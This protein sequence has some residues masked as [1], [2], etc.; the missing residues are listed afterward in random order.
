MEKKLLLLCAISGLALLGSCT[1]PTAGVLPV[2]PGST[3]EKAPVS[4]PLSVITVAGR[5]QAVFVNERG[6]QTDIVDTEPDGT[7]VACIQASSLVDTRGVPGF[8]AVKALI[9]GTGSDG[10]AGVWA[11]YSNDTIHPVFSEGARGATS[12]LPESDDHD[13]DFHKG[14]GWKY[15]V[16]ATS[17]DG[18]MIVGNA[19]NDKGFSRGPYSVAPG[20]TVGVY[21]RVSYVK[22][23]PN[24][25]VAR[26]R[27]IGV[28][29]PS[30][31][32]HPQGH[33]SRFSRDSTRTRMLASLQLFF[34]GY[35]SAYLVMAD[36]VSFDQTKNLYVVSGTDQ[37]DVAANATIDAKN[38]IAIAEAATSAPNLAVSSVMVPGAPVTKTAAWAL[39]ATV[40]NSGSAASASSTLTYQISTTSTLDTSATTIGTSTIPAVPAGQ[41]YTDTFSTTYSIPQSGTHWI[42]VTTGSSTS[43]ASVAVIYDRIFIDTFAPN[44]SVGTMPGT[45]ISLFGANGDTTPNDPNEY[46][47]APA[48]SVDGSVAIAEADGAGFFATLDYSTGLAPGT[49]YVRIRG[50]TSSQ[51][52]PYVARFLTLN[53]GDAPPTPGTYPTL[54]SDP[55][56][57]FAGYNSGTGVPSNPVLVSLGPPPSEADFNRYLNASDMDWF[58]LVLP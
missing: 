6:V 3:I 53:L 19:T 8:G 26:A 33:G 23:G 17:A 51:I 11:V 35:Y 34:L 52:G 47:T 43:S 49:Y 40:T 44:A 22:D 20:T 57:A 28:I 4:R 18:K 14:Q 38:L 9:T 39:G 5:N 13:M 27:V 7:V 42:F 10:G 54:T 12:R 55:Y 58:K 32:P 16:T 2:S 48:Y 45:F 41:S 36:S 21:W 50:E 25:S 46:G 24:L 30:K 29:D 56:P 37:D 15:S 1:L 31:L